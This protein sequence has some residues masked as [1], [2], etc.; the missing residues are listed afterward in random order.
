VPERGLAKV[1]A[2]K[3]LKQLF[4]YNRNAA[5]MKNFK[6]IKNKHAKKTYVII[7]SITSSSNFNPLLDLQKIIK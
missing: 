2:P 7:V 5:T 6:T 3:N 1:A 4:I